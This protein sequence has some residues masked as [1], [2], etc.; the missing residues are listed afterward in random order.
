[1]KRA[2][3]A[4]RFRLYP[5]GD[6][7]QGV[8]ER[9]GSGGGEGRLTV[10]RDSFGT[11]VGPWLADAY[12]RCEMIWSY[13]LE[14]GHAADDVLVLICERNIR[15]YLMTRADLS[16]EAPEDEEA[17]DRGDT[18]S[19]RSAFVEMDEDDDF[20]DSDEDDE[21]EDFDDEDEDF[22][23]EEDGFDSDEDDEDGDFDSAMRRVY[24]GI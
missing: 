9:D 6:Q 2:Y 21:D 8:F 7:A 15:D 23:E 20:F 19:D 10:F 14:S 4:Y 3:K 12:G 22:D 13:P 16:Y 24:D 17:F 11:A 18:L 1:M 5:D